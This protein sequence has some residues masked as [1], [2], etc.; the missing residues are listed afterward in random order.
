MLDPETSLESATLNFSK[1]PFS[2]HSL[3]LLI[4]IHAACI[5][6]SKNR[7]WLGQTLGQEGWKGFLHLGCKSLPVGTLKR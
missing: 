7:A 3:T 5:V 6:L 2:K 4:L 1:I